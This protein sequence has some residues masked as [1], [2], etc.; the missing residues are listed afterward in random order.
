MTNTPRSLVF[1]LCRR[2]TSVLAS[3][4]LLLTTLRTAGAGYTSHL[5]LAYG[6]LSP[7]QKLDLFVP[8]KTSTNSGPFPLIVRIHGGG[9]SGADKGPAETDVPAYVAGGFAVACINYRLSGEALFPA[10]AQDTKAA[11]RWLRAHAPAYNLDPDR[12]A[13]WGESSG[14]WLAV[15]LGVTGD[16]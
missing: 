4:L 9:F 8:T 11:V 1:E 7:A 3:A 10:A 14:A 15:M 5:N 12:F 6:S 2:P 13:A 16:Q